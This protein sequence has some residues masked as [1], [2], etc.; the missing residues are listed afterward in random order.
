QQD[1]KILLGG[2]FTQ[3]FGGGSPYFT[4]VLAGGTFEGYV[5]VGLNGPVYAIT[6][7]PDNMVLVGGDFTLPHTN[8]VRLTSVFMVDTGFAARTFDGRV[9]AIAVQP[10]GKIVVGGDFINNPA[11]Y[12]AR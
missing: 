4:R 2:D 6:I 9:R 12:A 5:G 1:G 8:L 7:Q 10:D 3:V 11:H